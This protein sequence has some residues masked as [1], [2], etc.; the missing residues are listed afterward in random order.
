MT[1]SCHLFCLFSFKIQTPPKQWKAW[2]TEGAGQDRSH[3]QL[4]HRAIRVVI[5]QEVPRGEFLGVQPGT[6]G[7]RG[8]TPVEDDLRMA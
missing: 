3:T 2:K 8:G 7:G 1:L 4:N 5:L 6:A